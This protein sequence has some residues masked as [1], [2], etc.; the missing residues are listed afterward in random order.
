MGSANALLEESLQRESADRSPAWHA[1]PASFRQLAAQTIGSVLLETA[2]PDGDFDKSLLFLEPTSELIAW[3]VHDLDR[4]FADLEH[5]LADGLFVA[6]WFSYECG[7]HFVGL[8]PKQDAALARQE[9]IA[10][11]GVFSAP[12]E[13]DHSSGVIRGALPAAKSIASVQQDQAD[14]LTGGLTIARKDYEAAIRKIHHYLQ[15]GDTYQI[16]F[17]DNVRGCTASEPLAL[18]KTLLKQQPVPFAAFLNEPDGPVLS[19]SPELFFR[20]HRGRIEVR[21]MKGTWRRGRDLKEDEAAVLHLRTDE[22]NR[23]EH[24]MIVDLLR[25]DLGRICQYGSVKVD[26]LFHVER[27][28]TLLQMTST[29]SGVLRD[30]VSPSQ[31]F[32]TMF[33]SGS[34]T[35]APKRRAMEIIHE[36]ERQ[37]RGVYTGAIGYFGPRGESCFNVAIRSLK[38]R[39]DQL[40]MGVGGGITAGSKA[41]E[42]FEECNLK[43]AFLTRRQPPFSL[44]ETM[45][46]DAGIPLLALHM[47][48]LSSS[49]RY[50][51]IEYDRT[52]LRTELAVAAESCGSVESRVR[53][54]LDGNG[55]WEIDATPLSHAPWRG[56]LLVATERTRSTDVFLRHKT[57]NRGLYDGPLAE[58]RKNGFDEL[59]FLNEEEC[60]TEGA[61]SNLFLRRGNKWITPSLDCGVLPGIKRRQ[62][63]KDLPGVEE[64]LLQLQDLEIADEIFLCNSLRGVRSVSSIE[65]VDGVVVWQ[66]QIPHLAGH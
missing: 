28:K 55:D 4:L 46:C 26:K 2:K 21:P 23:S 33:P 49:A 11:L 51:G 40:T 16:N 6:G 13:F 34:I 30:D 38:L 47:E 35:G 41:E 52:Q 24:V 36:L 10:R 57:T 3:T 14:I 15:E 61:I 39:G 31:I 45:R 66:K 65:R 20:T 56:R 37:P 22:K 48:R 63:L 7:E 62:L 59:L 44:I 9:P 53:I 60:L 5:H 32:A 64:G 27:Y 29:C 19:F 43:A 25:N 1:L 58:A 18:Y 17:T 12:I 54:E 8:P 42:E 50:F